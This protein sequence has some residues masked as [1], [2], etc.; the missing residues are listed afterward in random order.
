ML[1]VAAIESPAKQRVMRL[2]AIFLG[3]PLPL[4]LNSA[5]MMMKQ[6]AVCG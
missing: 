2:T 1:Q 5:N 6:I 3:N 4:F